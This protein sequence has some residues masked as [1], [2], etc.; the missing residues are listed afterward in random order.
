MNGPF[1]AAMVEYRAVYS[2]FRLCKQRSDDAPS[3]T[4]LQ[5]TDLG[6]RIAR[7]TPFDC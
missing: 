2:T 4:G 5:T 3:S 6:A 7:E 1:A